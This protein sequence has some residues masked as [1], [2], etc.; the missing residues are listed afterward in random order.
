MYMSDLPVVGDPRHTIRAVGLLGCLWVH[1]YINMMQNGFAEYYSVRQ[2]Y[3][4][5][6][7]SAI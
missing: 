1:I 5:Y 6:S 2:A 4:I 3:S 7:F